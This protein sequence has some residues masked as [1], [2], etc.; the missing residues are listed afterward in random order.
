MNDLLTEYGYNKEVLQRLDRYFF[1]CLRKCIQ[2]EEYNPNKNNILVN[3]K[4][5]CKDKQVQRII[6]EYPVK[7]LDIKPRFFLYLI[8]NERITFLNIVL[9]TG[10]L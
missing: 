2:Q 1:I 10:K 7:D 4:K 9:R 3:L 8:K 6:D 5:I